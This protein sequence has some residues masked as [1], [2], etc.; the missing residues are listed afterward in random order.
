MQIVYYQVSK[1]WFKIRLCITIYIFHS[2]LNEKKK[3][4]F[5]ILFYSQWDKRNKNKISNFSTSG[6]IIQTIYSIYS[7]IF[8][9]SS[10]EKGI[11]DLRI[12]AQI[13]S[14]AGNSHVN[15]ALR[16]LFG[17]A[18]TAKVQRS[19]AK[20]TVHWSRDATDPLIHI[21]LG[22]T[23]QFASASHLNC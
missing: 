1:T 20:F 23:P 7:N 8:H 15:R 22:C 3:L 17:A 5:F 13:S 4:K 9:H 11:F 19:K 16:R 21:K 14:P 10:F 12:I 18:A 2:S 6:K